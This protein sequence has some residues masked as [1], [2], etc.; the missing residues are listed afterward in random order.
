MLTHIA[1]THMQIVPRAGGMWALD[2]GEGQP[3]PEQ[4]PAR[5]YVGSVLCNVHD[6]SIENGTFSLGRV[7]RSS[8]PGSSHHPNFRVKD[9][10]HSASYGYAGSKGNQGRD[11]RN[12]MLQSSVGEKDKAWEHGG[13]VRGGQNVYMR[14]EDMTVEEQDNLRAGARRVCDE[15]H[16]L[17]LLRQGYAHEADP[18]IF[19]KHPGLV[20]G[21]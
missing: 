13:W 5:V 17:Q 3:T 15:L 14:A 10:M 18:K 7:T 21:D 1:F 4:V 8:V 19:L 11:S 20:L 2:L 6:Y 16:L 9:D 12:D